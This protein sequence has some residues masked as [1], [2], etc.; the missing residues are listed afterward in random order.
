MSAEVKTKR[1][2]VTKIRA[3][4]CGDPLV[5][6]TAYTAP[7]AALLDPYVDILLVGDSVGMVLHG[8][9]D[10]LG[11]D[12]DM[13][14]MHARA[15]MRG[16]NKALIAVDMPFGSYE[17][18]P[19]VAFRNAARVIQETG[20]TAV[21]I[22]GGEKMAETISFLNDRGIPVMGHVGLMPQSIN[23][24]GGFRVAG[25]KRKEW[26]RIEN[27]AHAVAQAGAF[28]VVLEGVAE[29]LAVKITKEIPIPTIGIGASSQCDGQI[30]VTE[31]MLG[32]SSRTP[33]FVKEYADLKNDIGRV[34]EAYAADVRSR[35][36]PAEEHTYAM[37]E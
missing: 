26:E 31:D 14:I 5:C 36:F 18:S 6:L 30:L 34:I 13:M 11:V 24:M 8:M 17:E 28:S 1:L 12:L 2:T 3:R 16:S 25:R 7:M 21:K 27:D 15:V 37:K 9:S 22:E 20:C 10:T 23:T 29:P 4:K 35:S 32:L 33:T 19:E